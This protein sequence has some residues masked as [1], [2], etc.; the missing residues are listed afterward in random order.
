MDM[1]NLLK[2]LACFA[3]V[4]SLAGCDTGTNNVDA[5]TTPSTVTNEYTNLTLDELVTAMRSYSGVCTVSTVNADGT[6]NIAVFVPAALPPDHIIFGW[7]NNATKENFLRTK[8]A[9][10]IYD[11]VNLG[12]ATKKDRHKGAK[13]V[14]VLEEDDTVLT[15]LKAGLIE[16]LKQSLI[17]QGKT[18]AEA[19]AQARTQVEAYTFCKIAE[20]IAVG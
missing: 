19:D 8:R 17:G 6:S 4:S 10:L 14:L 11:V 2:I 12:G 20:L 5:I 1:K 13:V 3:L 18:E 15:G 16:S 9:I 7:A